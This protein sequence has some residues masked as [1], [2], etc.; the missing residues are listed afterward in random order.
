MQSAEKIQQDLRNA[1]ERIRGDNDQLQREHS[2][3]TVTVEA[4]KQSISNLKSNLSNVQD[5]YNKLLEQIKKD[6]KVFSD[7][8]FQTD[9]IKFSDCVGCQTDS[10]ETN[11]AH[12]HSSMETDPNNLLSQLDTL[13]ELA[14]NL[15]F[16][17]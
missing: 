5:E 11:I 4:A 17:D 1:N 13:D 8:G 16:G 2:C 9:N 7:C 10:L 15:Y 14:R 12:E 6:K 3:L